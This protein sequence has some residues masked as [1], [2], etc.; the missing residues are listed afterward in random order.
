MKKC[1]SRHTCESCENYANACCDTIDDTSMFCFYKAYR[2]TEID[3]FG[4]LYMPHSS[5]VSI[6]MALEILFQKNFEHLS[7]QDML[8]KKIVEIFKTLT[9]THPCS[10]FPRLY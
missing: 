3:M 4:S 5:L 8:V 10:Q 6:I 9:L 7:V 1:L 2:Q